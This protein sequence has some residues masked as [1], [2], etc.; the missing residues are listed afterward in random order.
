M[1]PDSKSQTYKIRGDRHVSS[2]R[3]VTLLFVEL[4]EM[5][6]VE[7]TRVRAYFSILMDRTDK[8]RHGYTGR[9]SHFVGERGSSKVEA[10]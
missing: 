5:K 3:E 10:R 4:R 6:A 2:Y 7:Y 9:D 8:E 1:I